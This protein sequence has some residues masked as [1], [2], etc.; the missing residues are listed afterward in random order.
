MINSTNYVI[1]DRQA[2][3]NL[4]TNIT[5]PP[6][7]KVGHKTWG[8]CLDCGHKEMKHFNRRTVREGKEQFCSNWNCECEGFTTPLWDTYKLMWEFICGEEPFTRKRLQVPNPIK[9][10]VQKR[11]GNYCRYCHAEVHFTAT[12]NERKAVYDHVKPYSQGGETSI[13]NI[14]IACNACNRTKGNS[15]WMDLVK[16]RR[17]ESHE[18]E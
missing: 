14:V 13:E 11:D 3:K 10:A 7:I 15:N 18:S 4:V 8:I 12:V 1:N 9:T 2:P 5:R 6:A 16:P 17:K